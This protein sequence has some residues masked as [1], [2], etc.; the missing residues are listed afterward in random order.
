MFAFDYGE[1]CEAG[2]LED[3]CRRMFLGIRTIEY[4]TVAI[5]DCVARASVQKHKPYGLKKV[6]S[7]TVGFGACFRRAKRLGT[8]FV[9]AVIVLELLSVSESASAPWS[10]T[11]LSAVGNETCLRGK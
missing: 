8:A 4:I 9:V 10:N 11:R 1:G 6:F 2:G 3:L 7:K 5:V